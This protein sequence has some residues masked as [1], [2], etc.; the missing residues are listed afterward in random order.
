MKSQAL[1]WVEHKCDGDVSYEC[2]NDRY[3][4]S[5][6]FVGYDMF[7]NSMWEASMFDK[8]TFER[9][10]VSEYGTPFTS[11]ESAKRAMMIATK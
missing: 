1:K 6:E 4:G 9:V 10:P 11:V 7:G 8:E 3:C 2:E 5:I